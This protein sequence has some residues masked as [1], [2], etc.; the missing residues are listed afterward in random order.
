MTVLTTPL[1]LFVS[2]PHSH[3][4]NESVDTFSFSLVLLCLAAGDIEY[5]RKRRGGVS[6]TAYAEGWRPALPKHLR[7]PLMIAALIEEMW[8]A[9][10]RARPAMKEVVARLEACVSVKGVGDSEASLSDKLV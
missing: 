3:T 7:A 8:L 4:D 1:Y 10:F 2:S 9:D 6:S 5:V